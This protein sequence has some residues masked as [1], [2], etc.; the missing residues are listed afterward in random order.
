M[1]HI[2]KL[3]PVAA[4][5]M[6]VALALVTSA[7]NT[8]HKTK[9]GATLYSFEYNPPATDPYSVANVEN[10][11]NWVYTASS[12]G[13]SGNQEACSL[14]ASD[15]YVDNSG[16]SPVLESSIDI[17]AVNTPATGTARVS[18]IADQNGSFANQAK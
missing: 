4:M 17:Q 13:C 5:V 16:S 15:S 3:A 12:P 10:V 18:S 14:Q 1:I 8:P 6:G 9:G 11:S 7:F 2:K